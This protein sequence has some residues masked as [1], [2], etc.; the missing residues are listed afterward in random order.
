MAGN[1][2]IA[3]GTGREDPDHVYL[4]GFGLTR[5]LSDLSGQNDSRHFIGTVDYVAPEQI[6]GKPVDARTDIYLLGCVLY[7]CLTGVPPFERDDE[8]AL[9]WAYLVEQPPPVSA[10]RLGLP[11]GLD[12]VVA[13]AMA[14][15]PED[16]YGTCRELV[17]DFQAEIEAPAEAQG[18]SGLTATD[19]TSGSR[20]L[21]ASE[22]RQDSNE[23]QTKQ[24]TDEQAKRE[25]GPA[26]ARAVKGRAKQEAQE[27]PLAHQPKIFLCYR[28]EDTQWVARSIYES[29]SVKYGYERVFRD[30]DSTPMGVR[31]STWI[32]SRVS[33]C[34]VM[35]VLIGDAWA[36]AKDQAGRRRL[37]LPRDWVR[38]EIEAALARDIPIIPVRVQGA[39]M[40]S[41]EELPPSIVDLTSFQS[42]EIT[43][44]RWTFD[45]G[46]LMQAIDDLVA[47]S[48]NQ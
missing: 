12:A 39:R 26:E 9:L 30:I 47:S 8:A 43:D 41:E 3:S 13:K 35:I 45:V 46:R 32:E 19:R 48:G 25:A 16:R 15:A 28:R 36:S 38:Q 14:K 24:E 21:S 18:R 20:A 34:S 7:Q 4:T 22:Q 27:A 33:Q 1:I 37:E 31:Y 17:A 44:S 10:R 2:L 42:A 6:G 5:R 40:P 29:L 11:T 23:A